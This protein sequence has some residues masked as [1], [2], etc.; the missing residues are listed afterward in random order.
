[1]PI[2]Q[3]RNQEYKPRKDIDF[4]WPTFAKG[5]N[6]LLRENEVAKDE[7]T[8]AE[9]ITLKGKGVPTKRPGIALYYQSGNATGS[10]RGLHGLY[11]S[12]GTVDI[13]S[14]TDDGFLTIRTNASYTRVDGVSWASGNNAYMAQL[15][16]TLYIV[17]GDRELVKY[18]SPTLVGFPTIGLPAV[19]GATNLS[20]ATGATIKSYRVSAVSQ[21]GETLAASP[22]QLTGQPINLGGSAGGTIRLFITPPS[23]ASGVLRGM[24]IYGRNDG[25]E[26]F[27]G[28]LPG[29][30]TV[31]D[32][33]GVI[34]ASFIAYPPT[35][36]ST[37][38][39]KA[40]YVIRFHDRLVFAGLSGEPSK[41]LVSG[42]A[43]N[44]EKFDLSY[45][46][47][48][49][50]IEPDAGDDITGIAAWTDRIIVF[51]ER[52]IWEVKLTT[53]KAG[54]FFLTVPEA[55]LITAS[56][57]AIAPRS[58]IPVENDIFFLSRKGIYTLGYESG[59]AFD[60]L[61]TN[62]ISVRIRPF[63]ESLTVSQKKNAVATYWDNKYVITFPGLD[64]AMVFDRER[65]AWLGPWTFDGNV[66]EV[67]YDADENERLLIGDDDS[68]N[69]DE[70]SGSY[71]SDKGTA[72]QTLLRTRLE[73]F[74]DWSLFKNIKNIFTQFRNITGSVAVDLKLEKRNGSVVNAESFTVTPNTGNS[75]WGS[76]LWG[77][78][79]WGTSLV[80][81][82]GTDAQQTIKWTRLND[83][84][85]S[86]QMT[87][88]TTDANSNYELLGI[89]GKAQPIG[90]GYRPS[91]WK[92]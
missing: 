70:V 66:F 87:F 35:A 19:T 25:D 49:I 52:S 27:L 47:N 59:F 77:A 73:D 67:F 79:I 68:V 4:D 2:F 76:D 22:F 29:N 5:L 60:V 16:D 58:I 30:A 74:G 41:L 64:K 32:D 86:L 61:R 45:G 69:V 54:N 46:G 23:T 34:E 92:T 15:K 80:G 33:A 6:T 1:M 28:S 24:N 50:E 44:H 36:D 37:G 39:P 38:G 17:D 11:Y 26:R 7:L 10:V 43:P 9:N 56:H 57:G 12:N 55:K 82:G 89:K 51:K 42:R 85:R 53:E 75:G 14:L 63:F 40:K 20:N 88:K 71:T 48:Y 81:G 90:S 8:Q 31:F 78:A 65:L 84:A 83:A 62:E 3:T 91:R 13:V 21:V 72:I 18:S